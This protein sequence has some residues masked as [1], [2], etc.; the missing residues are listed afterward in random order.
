M[1]VAVLLS[2]AI[3]GGLTVLQSNVLSGFAL[4]GVRPD[5]VLIVIVYFANANGSFPGQITGLAS[6]VIRDLITLAPLGF[7]SLIYTAI[8]L[9]YGATKDK[10]FM[11]P[12]LVPMLMVLVAT[13]IKGV[14]G[15]LLAAVFGLENVLPSLLTTA[16]LIETGMNAVLTPLVFALLRV[17]QPLKVR[18]PGSTA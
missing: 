12:I 2:S 13:L 3:T 7:H 10:I 4:S 5:I 14:L 11:D 18:P 17:I 9:L 1:I 16:F 6:G 15:V 8:G